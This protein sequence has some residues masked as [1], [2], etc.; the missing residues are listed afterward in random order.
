[1]SYNGMGIKK[2][3]KSR[4]E[5]EDNHKSLWQG[6]EIISCRGFAYDHVIF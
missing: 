2:F 5:N 1:M 3:L 6:N 4:N